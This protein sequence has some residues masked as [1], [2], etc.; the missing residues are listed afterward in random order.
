MIENE[1]I[2]IK[3]IDF[4]DSN[5]IITL[6]TISGLKS[7]TVRGAQKPSSHTFNFA[8][9]FILLKY[10]DKGKY[11]IGGRVDNYYVNIINDFNKT[12][13][14]LRILEIINLLAL[15]INDYKI[16]YE[17]LKKCLELINDNYDPSLIE[18]IF[19]IK[20]LYL[21]GL[22]PNFS[23][24]TQCGCK[25]ELQYFSLFDGG[26]KC[27]NHKNI[28]DYQLSKN[29]LEILKIL[30]L[31]KLDKLVETI[32]SIKYDYDDLNKILNLFYSHFLGF[33]SN[34]EKIY[35]KINN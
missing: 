7:L 22:A 17:F 15:H 29:E 34:V 11:L 14:A 33:E 8:K 21:I 24:C 19:R 25:E 35:H 6:F 30:Y 18:L 4:G 12:K 3:S 13:C 28:N 1:G 32:N 16:S 2:V 9:E 31:V 27:I 26:M 10:E 23:S 20:F 5:K